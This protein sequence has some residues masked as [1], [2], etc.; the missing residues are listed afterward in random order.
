MFIVLA[1]SVSYC[2]EKGIF[3]HEDC[4]YWMERVIYRF[5]IFFDGVCM[6]RGTQPRGFYFLL[7]S[8]LGERLSFYTLQVALILYLTKEIGIA[9][10]RATFLFGLFFAL[11]FAAPLLG[12]YASDRFLGARRSCGIGAALLFSGY[13]FLVIPFP[14]LFFA[15]LGIIIL[16][17]GLFVPNVTALMHSLYRGK[18]PAEEKR[19]PIITLGLQAAA[20]LPALMLGYF[21]RVFGWG[22]GFFA[23]AITAAAGGILHLSG[24]TRL[25][26]A[27][28]LPPSSPLHG[29]KRAAAF[30]VRVAVVLFASLCAILFLFQF[31][32]ETNLL[33]ALGALTTLGGMLYTMLRQRGVDTV[34]LGSLLL[35]LV[36]SVGFWALYYQSFT[37][38]ILFADRTTDGQIF[39]LQVDAVFTRSFFPFFFLLLSPIFYRLFSSS[40]PSSTSLTMTFSAAGLLLALGFFL[41]GMGCHYF[42]EAGKISSW[43]LFGSAFLQTLGEAC[44]LPVS[45]L[46]LVRW[47]PKHFV[48]R[49]TDMWFLSQAAAF[50]I[51][52]FL[53]SA[54][55]S[56]S[57][58][59]QGYGDAFLLFGCAGLAL[60]ATGYFLIPFLMARRF[61]PV[62]IK[63]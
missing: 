5:S 3:F 9:D 47:A 58:S 41:L 45:L 43:W 39:G 21:I 62:R 6:G 53:G 60:A 61:D 44:L 37:T 30:Y 14:P 15:G 24:R 27:G 18:D 63:T 16:G 7:T 2:E 38:W 51:A 40:T 13:L 48:H 35:V 59:A 25:R 8:Q 34:Q 12:T 56:T 17:S 55:A 31:P 32:K 23:A 26:S 11:L 1:S 10:Q 29:H 54:A 46:M 36:L 52:A 4:Q 33:M 22:A 50:S 57:R 20:I 28:G 42:A 19:N 49:I